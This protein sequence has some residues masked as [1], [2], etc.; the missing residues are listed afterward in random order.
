MGTTKFILRDQRPFKKGKDKGRSPVDMIYSHHGERKFIRTKI[1]LFPVN[2]EHDEQEVIFVDKAEAKKKVPDIDFEKLLTTKD[3]KRMNDLIGSYRTKVEDIESEFERKGNYGFTS[4]DVKREFTGKK[5]KAGRAS[6][7]PKTSAKPIEIKKSPILTFVENYI[8]SHK[9]DRAKGSL[10]V[11]RRLKNHLVSM[12]EKQNR[13]FQFA[14]TDKKFMH[15]FQDFLITNEKLSDITTAK[16]VSVFKTMLK[17]AAEEGET[18]NEGYKN[19]KKIKVV[20]KDVIAL[21]EQELSALINLDLSDNKRLD[22]ARDCLVL[23]CSTGLRYSDMQLLKRENIFPDYIKI[24]VK[25]TKEILTIPLTPISRN[26]IKKY[27]K[28]HRP[29]PIVSNVKLNLFVKEVCK[30]A[31]IDTPTEMVSYIGGEPISIT[32]PKWEWITV[33]AGRRSF[34]TLSLKGGMVPQEVMKVTGHR[35][36]DSFKKYIK[37]TEEHKQEAMNKTWEKMAQKNTVQ[38]K[39]NSRIVESGDTFSKVKK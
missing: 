19:F 28:M 8:D 7:L 24:N 27:S 5:V 12:M 26:I 11:H 39:R 29:I 2:W 36:F 13:I 34:A 18:V 16:M 30:E 17:L 4:E 10:N 15:G 20:E 22:G 37:I 25:K 3:V 23:S 1:K 35:S 32:K 38:T 33:H 14:E 6:P 9:N 21:T 31:K